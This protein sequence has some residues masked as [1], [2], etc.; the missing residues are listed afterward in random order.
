M[1]NLYYNKTYFDKASDKVT[2]SLDN[3]S[4]ILTSSKAAISNIPSDFASSSKAIFTLNSIINLCEKVKDIKFVFSEWQAELY[5]KYGGSYFNNSEFAGAFYKLYGFP[6]DLSTLHAGINVIEDPNNMLASYIIY[7]PENYDGTTSVGL[8]VIYHDAGISSESSL[9]RQYVAQMLA[10]GEYDSDSIILFPHA[11]GQAVSTSSGSSFY[12][13]EKQDA[14][15]EMVTELERL[16]NVDEDKVTLT[17]SSSAQPGAVSTVLNNVE[18]FSEINL[19]ALMGS[20]Y[21]YTEAESNASFQIVYAIKAISEAGVTVNL[22]CT[23]DSLS[24]YN[25]YDNVVVHQIPSYGGN[26]GD[27]IEQTYY[28]SEFLS[29]IGITKKGETT[30]SV[31]NEVPE[32]IPDTVSLGRSESI[33]EESTEQAE[34]E[35]GTGDKEIVLD[36]DLDTIEEVTTSGTSAETEEGTGDKEIVLDDDLDTIEEVTTSGTSAETKNGAN[37]ESRRTGVTRTSTTTAS[38]AKN[39]LP[40]NKFSRVIPEITTGTLSG[41][42]ISENYVIYNINDIS[43]SIYNNYLVSLEEAGYILSEDG[44][45]WYND[46]YKVFLT[47][48]SNNLN[49]SIY[50]IGG[51]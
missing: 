7:I 37:L 14:I 29:S 28:S 13:T 8:D 21:N 5:E 45:Y 25:G 47:R 18:Y 46:L 43:E 19:I 20:P 38:V 9:T 16:Y 3:I 23:D 33:V 27:Q 15:M 4:S 49:I 35:E 44:T 22:Y 26:H 34:T 36:D 24:L 39:I 6:L 51:V 40:D 10:S 17:A 1:P 41:L 31:D 50:S 11:N 48:E 12:C 32:E 42:E 2:T 30:V